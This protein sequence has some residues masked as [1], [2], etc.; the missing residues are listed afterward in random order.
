MKSTQPVPFIVRL[1][2]RGPFPTN[3][4]RAYRLLIAAV[5]LLSTVVEVLRTVQDLPFAQGLPAFLAEMVAEFLLLGDFALQ[6][7]AAV[8]GR[9]PEKSRGHAFLSY[10]RSPYGLVDFLAALPMSSELLMSSPGD[11]GAVFGILRFL[12]LARYSPALEILVAVV[13]RE[14]RPLQ[15]ATFILVLMLLVSSTSLY[16]IERHINPNFDS[17]PATMWWS[18]ATLTTVGYGDVVPITGLGKLLGGVVA[19]LGIA[20]FALPASI[21]ATGF[22]EE[23]RRRDFLATWRMVARVPFFIGLDAEQIADITNLLRFYAVPPGDAVIR[24]GEVGDR[25]Y[26]IVS[27][28]LAADYGGSEPALLSD[29]DFFGEIALLRDSRRTATVTARSRCQLLI[30]DAKDLRHFLEGSP[31]IGEIIAKTAQQRL[32]EQSATSL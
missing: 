31:Q 19:M 32:N 24:A 26:F 1:T 23:M 2:D 8:L 22:A 15:S 13:Q 27:G 11:W 10:L 28:L 25:M 3:A 5:V 20:M 7:T 21:L 16:F 29:G 17:I 9:A 4:A 6:A 12:K 14:V 30:L 18:V